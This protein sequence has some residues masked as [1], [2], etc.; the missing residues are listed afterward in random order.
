MF[1]SG[2]TPMYTPPDW[3]PLPATMPA[4]CVQ[5]R[6]DR[7]WDS[8]SAPVLASASR[9]AV[10]WAWA[11]R[12][13]EVSESDPVSGWGS[14]WASELEQVSDLGSAWALG[15]RSAP[16]WASELEQVSDLGS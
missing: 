1:A 5:S 12:S 4:T 2:A 6:S 3:P 13:A 11:S 8:P 7:A 16:G 14:A 9:P 10:V 15:Y